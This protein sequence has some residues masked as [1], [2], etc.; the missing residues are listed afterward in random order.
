MLTPIEKLIQKNLPLIIIKRKS[1]T[2]LEL[3]RQKD[4]RQRPAETFAGK[5]V[6]IRCGLELPGGGYLSVVDVDKR[7]GGFEALKCIQEELGFSIDQEPTAKW[8]TGGG[9]LHIA[10]RSKVPLPKCKLAIGIDGQGVGSYVVGPGSEHESGNFYEWIDDSEIADMPEVLEAH[11]LSCVKPFF[12][13]SADK[14]FTEESEIKEGGRNNYLTKVAGLLRRNGLSQDEIFDSISKVNQKKCKPPVD[15]KELAQIS[16]SVMKYEHS[17]F[18]AVL[19]DEKPSEPEPVSQVQIKEVP[20]KNDLAMEHAFSELL[21]SSQGLVKSISTNILNH[22][23]RQYPQFA[24]ATSLSIIATCA[25]GGHL[26]PSMGDGQKGASLCQNIWLTAPSAAGKN[27]Y[28]HAAETYLSAVDPRLVYD[29]IGSSHGL[30]SSLYVSN[31]GIS[32]IDEFQ[33]VLDVIC[34]S[35]GGYMSQ[36]ITDIKEISNDL[37]ELRAVTL[38]KSKYPAIHFPRYSILGIGTQEGFLRHLSSNLVGGGFMS[39]FSVWPVVSIPSRI[40][41]SRIETIPDEQK[42]QLRMLYKIGLTEAGEKQDK[43]TQ[44]DEFYSLGPGKKISHV[45]QHIPHLQMQMTKKAKLLMLD[46]Y[47]SQEQLFKFHVQKNLAGSDMSPG[48]IADRA[49]R[50]ALQFAS[51][52][53]LGREGLEVDEND[54]NF[55]IKLSKILADHL[56]ELLLTQSGDDQFS[57]DCST[58]LRAAKGLSQ[59]FT[60]TDFR[61]SGISSR[62]CK[63]QD[64]DNIILTLCGRGELMAVDENMNLRSFDDLEQKFFLKGTRRLERGLKFLVAEMAEV[65]SNI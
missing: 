16:R 51:L 25:Q 41:S 5:N 32:I 4:E 15:D 49:P 18:S 45:P 35:S 1:K 13:G 36:I 12:D 30:R 65:R 43:Q 26:A 64:L 37:N 60:K 48:S 42:E 57:K 14:H 21:E 61:R 53:C 23:E 62:I 34:K 56:C 28:K 44:L 3:W 46:F 33:D 38:A 8:R 63:S 47:S 22:C 17:E 24:M 20:R 11:W 10:F 59:P 31:S 29:S 2:P 55:G 6:G 40:Y 58:V 19:D 9:G 27:A 50:K 39:R 7:S 54:A 52:H